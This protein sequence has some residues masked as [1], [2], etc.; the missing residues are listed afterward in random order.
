MDTVAWGVFLVFLLGAAATSWV[1]LVLPWARGT[2]R[3]QRGEDRTSDRTTTRA[4][5]PAVRAA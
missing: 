3:L 5:P 4:N 2:A 1:V